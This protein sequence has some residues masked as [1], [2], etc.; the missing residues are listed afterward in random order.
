MADRTG[1]QVTSQVPEVGFSAV[2][3]DVQGDVQMLYPGPPNRQCCTNWVEEYPESLK[4]S[5]GQE[6]ESKSKALVVR[7]GM[8][9]GGDGGKLL[10]LDS[11]IVQHTGVKNLLVDVFHGYGGITADLKKLFFRAPLHAFYY[12]WERFRELLAR[13]EQQWPPDAAYSQK[14]FEIV[15]REL[16]HTMEELNSLVSKGLITHD[17]L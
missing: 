9:H 17:L 11:I 10:A 6:L 12:R 14:L 5:V 1:F 8:N 3:H 4:D 7:M 15:E 2:E 16:K 13:Q